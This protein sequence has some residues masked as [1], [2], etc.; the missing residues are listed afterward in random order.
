MDHFS[1]VSA[2]GAGSPSFTAT[3][4]KQPSVL[5]DAQLSRPI[6]ARMPWAAWRGFSSARGLPTET[7][8][9]AA[10]SRT[11]RRVTVSVPVTVTPQTNPDRYQNSAAPSTAPASRPLRRASR[12]AKKGRPRFF[13]RRAE[14]P[15][16]RHR[17]GSRRYSLAFIRARAVSSSQ[18]KSHSSRPF[19]AAM[20]NSRGAPPRTVNST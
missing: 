3:S 17:G 1:W 10:A 13:S 19:F 9:C 6:W 16:R 12:A 4:T 11:C 14:A 18:A 2:S 5:T 8:Y 20:V 7:P 15:L